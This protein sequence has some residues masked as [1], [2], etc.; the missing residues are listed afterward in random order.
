MIEFLFTLLTL[1]V[2]LLISNLIGF[3]LLFNQENKIDFAVDK[4]IYLVPILG[5][6]FLICTVSF[7]G[8]FIPFGSYFYLIV[9][10]VIALFNL[11]SIF[12]IF[13]ITMYL[14]LISVCVSIPL[15]GI[16][17]LQNS[18]L[19]HND[20]FTYIAIS[21]WLQNNPFYNYLNE[22]SVTASSSQVKLYQNFGFRM[23]AIYLMS[24]FQGFFSIK[25]SFFIYHSFVIYGFFASIVSIYFFMINLSIKFSRVQKIFILLLPSLLIGGIQFSALYGFM[26]QLFGLCLSFISLILYSDFL[27]NKNLFKK[28]YIQI[29]VLSSCFA[30]SIITYS[31]FSPFL[32]LTLFIYT[33]AFIIINRKT[34]D[35]KYYFKS[36]F[37]LLFLTLFFVNLEL[38]R[39]YNSLIV[40]S[41]AIVGSLI[42][43]PLY[44]FLLHYFGVHGGGWDFYQYSR[45]SST[46]SFFFLTIIVFISLSYFFNFNKLPKKVRFM[47]HPLNILNLLFIIFLLFFRY[48]SENP[49]D[50]GVGQTWSQF[51]IVDWGGLFLIPLI[52]IGIYH[53]KII[54]KTNFILI[55]ILIVLIIFN[56]SLLIKR[57]SHYTNYYYPYNNIASFFGEL[58]EKI[59][60]IC[61]PN[62]EINIK[63]DGNDHK[64]KQFIAVF[65]DHR[66]LVSDFSKDGYISHWIPIMP[67]QVFTPQVGQCFINKSKKND[68]SNI[69]NFGPINITFI[70]SMDDIPIE[71]SIDNIYPEEFDS[72]DSWFWMGQQATINL[73]YN[74]NLDKNSHEELNILFDIQSD[75]EG[76]IDIVFINDKNTSEYKKYFL[77]GTNKINLNADFLPKKIIFR[78]NLGL[79]QLSEKDSR[80][81]S[82]RI[83]NLNFKYK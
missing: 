48:F 69:N 9:T 17:Y 77:K 22:D 34:I 1:F 27:L 75:R 18:F 31:E 82:V 78:T 47:L 79:R 63:L 26:P 46:I 58:E 60:S 70:K 50:R 42:D 64:L 39:I 8:K 54:F 68:F 71:F 33:I 4:R 15:L 36:I 37:Y 43:W 66:K 38:P 14:F 41:G 55:T 24:F 5:I 72:S 40:Q 76:Y 74:L 61:P 20:T 7:L 19:F 53:I 83:L 10:F 56:F 73:K 45:T 44:G 30:S 81:V 12:K 51:K 28:Y 6:S 62:S 16:A 49:Y 52:L 35:Y 21:D 59:N 67:N 11:P 3:R 57:S 80:V 65:L 29:F 2:F 32:V 23:G 25:Y 13:K